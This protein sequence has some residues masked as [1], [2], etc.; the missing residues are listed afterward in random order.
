MRA[1]LWCNGSTPS[2]RVTNS[3]VTG[4]ASLFGVDGGAEK[5]SECGFDV[6]EA[7]GDLDSLDV[8]SWE[9]AVQELPGQSSSDLVKSI[10]LLTDRGFG[11]IDVIGVE[12]GS[13]EHLLG[14]WAALSESPHGA[15]IRLHHEGHVT[16]RLHPEEGAL[17]LDIDEGV[18]FSVFALETGRVWLEGARWEL[19]GEVLSFSTRGLHNEGIGGLVSIRSEAVL[20]VVTPR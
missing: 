2:R 10:G 16:R 4:D 13:P 18:I 3:V 6:I 17:K 1:V 8:E 7:I 5:A 15:I 20:A 19:S 12:G 9:G 11:E 14:N